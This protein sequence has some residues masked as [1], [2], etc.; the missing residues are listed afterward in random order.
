M[1]KNHPNDNIYS[2]LGK[3]ESLKP[4]PEEARFALVKEIRESIEA[5]G[6]VVE[7]VAAVEARLKEQ[8]KSTITEKAVSQAQQKFMGMVHAA[9]KGEKPASKEVAKVAKGMGKKDAKDFAATKHKGL[10]QHVAEGHCSKCDCNPCECPTNE[11]TCN[12]CGM[13]EGECKHTTN[14]NYKHTGTYGTE[15]Y[16]SDDFT[17]GPDDDGERKAGRPRTKPKHTPKTGVKGRPKKA[18]SERSSAKLPKFGKGKFDLPAWPKDKT[19]I[20]KIAESINFK[21]MMEEQHMT[22][23][24]ML[25][26]LTNDINEYKNSGSCSENLRDF[27]EVFSHAK[28]QMSEVGIPGNLPPNQ[29]PG[30]QALLKTPVSTVGKI[31]SAVK[32][33]LGGL[34]DFATGK[35]ESPTRP[36]FEAGLEEELNDLAR[37][38]GLAVGEGVDKTKFAALAE[39]KDKITYADKIAGAKK[40]NNTEELDEE[41]NEGNAFGKAVR[42]AK[43]DGVQPGEKV[44]VGDKEYPVKESIGECGME[45]SDTFNVSTNMSSDGEKNVTIS[46]SGNKASELL[47]MLKLAGVDHSE[48]DQDVEVVHM[49]E[50]EI[51][52]EIPYD[53][54]SEDLANAPD[55]QYGTVDQIVK[56]G[57]DLN[58]SK[59]QFKKE[60]PGDNPMTPSPTL[61]ARLQ[62]EYDSIKKTSK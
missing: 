42:D 50:E 53:E 57:D 7:G 35:P 30:K 61:E 2:I 14:E 54:G 41:P 22:L 44:K 33:T 34:K 52:E 3:L 32:D 5:Q 19:R 25:D 31:G 1:S 29:V 16:K 49:G 47:Q 51:A 48:Q 40:N 27:M 15:Y 21:R 9:Q 55:E 56:Q 8:F 36:T 17:G 43:A 12:E 18:D 23:D 4:T 37:L 46:A 20:H 13:M 62:A 6:S 24:E 58:R 38:A 10:P 45:G 60:Y 26:S 39:P 28:K 59:K 11:S